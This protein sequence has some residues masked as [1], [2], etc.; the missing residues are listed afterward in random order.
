LEGDERLKQ[1]ATHENGRNIAMRRRHLW[2]DLSKLRGLGMTK[3]RKA[4]EKIENV[5]LLDNHLQ[6]SGLWNGY[7]STPFVG[8]CLGTFPGLPSVF[9]IA[10]VVPADLAPCIPQIISV[11]HRILVSVIDED[12]VVK[13][14]SVTRYQVHA[15]YLI[16]DKAVLCDVTAGR[17]AH[18]QPVSAI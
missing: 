13:E 16:P 5:M 12:V 18:L 7:L 9:L 10:P 4:A 17:S 2:R 15:R 6:P 3:L 8:I 14:V 11:V 1:I